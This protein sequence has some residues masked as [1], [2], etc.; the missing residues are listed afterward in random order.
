M[1]FHP[2]L[3]LAG[4]GGH[5]FHPFAEIAD[6]P[7]AAFIVVALFVVGGI[8]VFPV[9]LLIAATAATFGPW[10]GFAYAASGALASALVTG[11]GWVR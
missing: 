10:L 7:G 4:C 1:A 11:T 3:G 5:S 6:M 8:L 9:L 2:A